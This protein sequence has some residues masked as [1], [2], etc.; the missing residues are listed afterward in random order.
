M[1]GTLTVGVNDTG[2]DVKFFGATSGKYMQWDESADSLLVAGTIDVA[3][4]IEFDSLSGTGAVAI[5]DILDQDDLSGNSATALATQQ[6]I[7]AYVDAN[8]GGTLAEV[9]A[10]GNRTT[11]TQKIE[12][13]DAAIYIN[14]STDGQ[15]DIVADTEIQIAATTIDINGAVN[16]S[17]EIIAASLDISGNID[18]D[19]ITNLDAVDID[20]AVQIDATLS[21]GVDD[22]GYDVKFFGATS[23]K[24][25]LWDESADSLIV[26]GTLDVAGAI[27]FN[28]LSGTGSVTITDILDQDDMS[29]N[30]ATMLATQQ[31]IKA[32]VDSNA[33]VPTGSE[34]T[35]ATATLPT[36]WL[37]ENGAAISRSTYSALF[38]VIGTEYGAGDGSSTF[39]LPD[40]R[41]EFIRGW[42]HGAG[43]DPDAAARTNRG[44]GTAGDVIGSKQ[45]DQFQGHIFSVRGNN[46]NGGDPQ[47]S[48]IIFHIAGSALNNL[49]SI[50]TGAQ[51]DGTN[52]TPRTG[53]ETRA[54]NTYRM[55][56]I[57]Y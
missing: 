17:G 40:A 30:S 42:D 19:G 31:S 24:S 14:S 52:G 57:K 26:T 38:A 21:V 56:I 44:D 55:I 29:T 39:N 7:K 1:L 45:L 41:G 16:A 5:T 34:I 43:T 36:G 4:A 11:T 53:E 8:T 33:G 25:L 47:D 23:G 3:G 48:N 15:L 37:E 54:R 51:S 28:S 20:G 27:E 9:L 35:W 12:F 32:Y 46:N 6:S 50:T 22:T 49:N 10:N 18:V 13:R 2:H